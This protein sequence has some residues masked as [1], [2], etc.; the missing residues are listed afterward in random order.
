MKYVELR[1]RPTAESARSGDDLGAVP[2]QS[3]RSASWKLRNWRPNEKKRGR[4]MVMSLTSCELGEENQALPVVQP[5]DHTT[6]DWD[7][8]H[9]AKENGEKPPCPEC[10]SGDINEVPISGAKY[11]CRNCS[12]AYGDAGAYR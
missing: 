2:R 3:P 7:A 4:Q 5:E 6:V 12:H 8:Y 10:G 9:E 1:T 11:R